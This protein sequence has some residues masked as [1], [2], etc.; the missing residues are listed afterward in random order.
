MLQ[1]LRTGEISVCDDKNYN[2]SIPSPSTRSKS[3]G[4][5]YT[6][7]IKYNDDLEQKTKKYPFFPETTKANIDQFTVYQKEYNT[8]RC[9]S[10]GKVEVDVYR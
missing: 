8:K 5:I 3:I 1:A 7:D 9:K 10:K 6:I 2:G 4:Y